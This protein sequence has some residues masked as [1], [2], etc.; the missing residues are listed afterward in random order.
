VVW[1]IFL[2]KKKRLKE[3]GIKRGLIEVSTRKITS[4]NKATPK[5][6]IPYL[7]NDDIENRAEKVIEYFG[8][9]LLVSPQQIP[10]LNFIEKL[11]SGRHL[12]FICTEDLGATSSNKKI[13]G[14]FR[15]F[16]NTILVD[17]SLTPADPRFLFT[18]AHEFGHFVLHR[19]IKVKQKDYV[20]T[21]E[22][23]D[24]ITGRKYFVTP[25]DWLEGQ[26]NRF[27]S[28]ILMPRKTFRKAIIK[29]QKKMSISRNIGIIY[30]DKHSYSKRDYESIK[31]ALQ[32]IYGINKTNAECRLKDLGILIDDRQKDTQCISELL[33]EE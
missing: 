25:K 30:L 14:A 10:V 33:Y 22:N 16:S 18:L 13:L 19:K 28:A 7:S 15:F 32:E 21:E 8:K 17:Q 3:K 11:Q 23:Y 2:Y 12:N 29:I 20:D 24:L 5:A 9:H 31:T 26:A 1:E 6:D 27:A 4:Q